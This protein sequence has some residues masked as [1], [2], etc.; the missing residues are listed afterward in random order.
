MKEQFSYNYHW[1][2]F[3]K[4]QCLYSEMTICSFLVF[5]ELCGEYEM[6]KTSNHESFTSVE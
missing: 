3:I 5:Y 4:K 2:Y 1:Y 6:V